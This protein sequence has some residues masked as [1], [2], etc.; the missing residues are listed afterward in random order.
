MLPLG[1]TGKKESKNM[2]EKE[3]KAAIQR[4][5]EKA[6]DRKILTKIYTFIKYLK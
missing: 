2:S 3:I 1:R 4:M 6:S 5:V